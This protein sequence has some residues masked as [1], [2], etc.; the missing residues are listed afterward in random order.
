MNQPNLPVMAPKTVPVSDSQDVLSLLRRY[1]WLLIAGAIAGTGTATA[2]FLYNWRTNSQYTA[3]IPF[4]V[5]ERPTNVGDQG[6]NVTMNDDML[7]VLHRQEF[8]FDE[9]AFLQEVLKS[10]EFHPPIDPTDPDKRGDCKWLAENKK[11]PLK[12]LRRDL[13]I[14]PRVD[15]AA[16]DMTM[17]TRDPNESVSLVQ[18]AAKVYK[19]FLEI[20]SAKLKG[21]NLSH[22]EDALKLQ[23]NSYA[24]ESSE[25]ADYAKQNGIDV[26]RSRFEVEKSRL[27]S[28]NEDFMKYDALAQSAKQQYDV[29]KK[30]VDDGKEIELTPDLKQEIENDQTLRS[31]QASRLAWEQEMVAELSR[32]GTPRDGSAPSSQRTREIVARE[33]EID[34]QLEVTRKKLNEDARKRMEEAYSNDSTNKLAL[35]QYVGDKRT[36]EEKVVRGLG[37]ELMSYQQR[38]DKLN[39]DFT[40]LG[41]IRDQKALADMNRFT[42]DTRV[43]QLIDTPAI[44]DHPS[45]PKWY[46]FIPLGTVAGLGLSALLAYLLT[47]TDTRVR[48]PRDITRTLQ[49]PLLGFV[50]D[51]SDDRLLVGEVETAILSSPASMIAESFRQ[52][53]SHITAQ[54]AHNPANTL[55][56]TS[57]TAGGGA[58]TVAANFAAAMALNDLRVL[59]IDANLYRPS[60]SRIFKG[61]PAEGLA[62]AIAHPENASSSIVP[63]PSLP[64]LHLMGAG[65]NL[66]PGSS[67]IFESKSFRE[68]L[69]QLKSRYDLVI[70]DGAPL[71]LVADSLALGARVD[72]V[73]SVVRA[74]EVSRGAV[75][76]IR[77][78]LR[79]V[80]ANLLGFVL[81][82]A[83]TS[84]TGYFKENYRNFYHYA[85]KNARRNP[86]E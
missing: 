34:R 45:W 27:Q 3:R 79:G 7:Q 53:R 23:E 61:M 1:I 76:R 13:R 4:Q 35:A 70:F 83:Q 42:D 72:G 75:S 73:V 8:V 21:S 10:D 16:F 22:L 12:Y 11:D 19:S 77:E 24:Y 62:D 28:L 33:A 51:E 25:L 15:A 39:E 20:Q 63:H 30:M 54:T 41:K 2:L 84:N 57:V 68:L 58:T 74:G 38:V 6:V 64:T 66:A 29:I 50:P 78:Q 86:G 80:H 59:L 47:L 65:S 69:E 14:E 26:Q 49:L 40:L 81:N 18:A 48:T 55:L 56:I 5:L 82:A 85:G 9:D 46:M 67:E 44:P 36:E 71:S 37:Q 32:I 52:I 60:F 31:L 17:T 43:Q